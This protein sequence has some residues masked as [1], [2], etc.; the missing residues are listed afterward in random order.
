M[1]SLIYLCPIHCD[2]T[3][4][5]QNWPA[6]ASY[7]VFAVRALLTSQRHT[8][9][10]Q[11]N[12]SCTVR[13]QELAPVQQYK[14]NGSD[15]THPLEFNLSIVL[16]VAEISLLQLK[17]VVQ[18]ASVVLPPRSR[19]PVKTESCFFKLFNFLQTILQL[20]N[21]SRLQTFF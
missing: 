20:E 4:T 8:V 11:D 3:G 7:F 19:T 13:R 1:N 17:K 2:T 16:R 15:F 9:C 5:C 18:D 6:R 10:F 12:F 21:F 14:T